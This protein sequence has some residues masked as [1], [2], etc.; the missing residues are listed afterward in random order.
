MLQHGFCPMMSCITQ[1]L[2]AIEHWN[3]SL[4]D[5]NNVDIVY[6]FLQGI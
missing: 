2:Q 5:G 4:D 3:K 6:L 1:L